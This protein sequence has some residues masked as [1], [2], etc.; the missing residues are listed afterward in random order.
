[1][2][3]DDRLVTIETDLQRFVRVVYPD[4]VVRAEYWESRIALFFIDER[5]RGLYPR[6]RYHYLLRPIPEDYRSTLE[7]TVWFELT[8]DEHPEDIEHSDEELIAA[9]KQDVLVALEDSG[10]FTTLDELLCPARVDSLRHECS[11][12]FRHSKLALEK[13]GFAESDWSDVFHVLMDEGGF[14]DCEILY[15][16]ASES[17]LKANHWRKAHSDRK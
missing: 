15:N 10:F 9:I 17:R 1:M 16:V 2:T 8:P 7:N 3:Q 13:S 4:M 12:D 14:C 6:Q 5:F 11:G